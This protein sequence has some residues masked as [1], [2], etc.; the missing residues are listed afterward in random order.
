MIENKTV[1]RATIS[2]V[3]V[4]VLLLHVRSA[5]KLDAVALAIVALGILPWLS[6]VIESAKLPGGW[7]VKFRQVETE[8][9]RQREEI[10]TLRFLVE[11]F[12]T[13]YE[14]IHLNKLASDEPFAFHK[15]D[16][17]AAELRHLLA[18]GF[19]DRKP[20]K[21]MRSLFAAADDVKNHLAITERG[22]DYLKYRSFVGRETS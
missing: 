11:N 8:Q 1:V 6:S 17:F 18:L 10:A 19:I 3:A 4:V 5:F 7:E 16:T 21:G 13:G 22:R 9:A 2:I 20:G 15:S 12:I 14:L